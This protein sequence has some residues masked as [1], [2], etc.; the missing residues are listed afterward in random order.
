MRDLLQKLMSQKNIRQKPLLIVANKQDLDDSL[1]LVDITYFF[2]IDELA[3]LLGTPCFIATCGHSNQNDLYVG[4]DWLVDHI[5]ANFH[6]LTNRMRFNRSILSPVGK[7]R[8]QMTA[9]PLRV[10]CRYK[11]VCVYGWN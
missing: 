11:N 10:R 3:N 6:S 7:F 4:M 1:D 8:R 2:H 9:L 5:V